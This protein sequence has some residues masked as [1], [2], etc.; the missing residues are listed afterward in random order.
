[1]RPLWNPLQILWICDGKHE[2]KTQLIVQSAILKR[3]E[4]IIV[5]YKY[6]ALYVKTLL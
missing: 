6:F 3:N 5:K 1:M 4:L 2:L